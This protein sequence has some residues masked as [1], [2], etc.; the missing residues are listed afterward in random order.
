MNC[1]ISGVLKVNFYSSKNH[2]KQ[3]ASNKIVVKYMVT[4]A[5]VHDSKRLQIFDNP[6]KTIDKRKT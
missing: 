5:C 1:S 2:G 3:D 4:D 6:M